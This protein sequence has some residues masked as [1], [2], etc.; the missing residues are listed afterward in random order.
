MKYLQLLLIGLAL[1]I[2][3]QMMAQDD[4]PSKD[5]YL[6]VITLSG[7]LIEGKLID[8][9]E[10]SFLLETEI[11][12]MIRIPKMEIATLVYIS[13]D[14]IGSSGYRDRSGEINP[15]SSRYLFAPS[16]FNLEKG[17]G[18]YHN[19]WFVYNQISY[20]FT[21][22]ITAGISMTPVGSGGTIKYGAQLTEKFGVSVGAIAVTP[23]GNSDFKGAGIGFA[24]ATVGTERKNLS[25]SYGYG[26]YKEQ[27][28]VWDEITQDYTNVIEANNAHMINLSGLM[29]V[30]S[31]LWIVTENY[32][33]F[34]SIESEVY[35]P[36]AVMSVGFRRASPKRDVVWD[37]AMVSLPTEGFALPWLSITVPF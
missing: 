10:E 14:E 24:N 26:F 19:V 34:E 8:S 7:N 37:Y 25:L 2:S 23:F 6:R 29:E 12:G 35:D 18:Y 16:S 31:N 21:D 13:E 3:P 30:N 32:F 15:R 22:H 11:M 4:A 36:I 1:A 20:G 28:Y 27:D 5:K 17:E 9:D 33:I